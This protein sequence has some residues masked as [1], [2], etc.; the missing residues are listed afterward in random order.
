M[1]EKPTVI[2]LERFVVVG[3][4]ADGSMTTELVADRDCRKVPVARIYEDLST[5]RSFRTKAL[6]VRELAGWMK[7]TRRPE[8]YPCRNT[9]IVDVKIAKLTFTLG[10]TEWV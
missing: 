1:S 6:N 4:R 2:T 5:A 9:D 7:E 8:S 3:F 10:D